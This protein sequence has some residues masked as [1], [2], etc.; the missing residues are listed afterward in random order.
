MAILILY[1][2]EYFSFLFILTVFPY[3]IE[4]KPTKMSGPKVCWEI[5]TAKVTVMG[6]GVN[7]EGVAAAFKAVIGVI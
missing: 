2:F 4:E 5:E 7:P 3:R 6:L 1:E